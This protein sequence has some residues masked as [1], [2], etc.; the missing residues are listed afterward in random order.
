MSPSR[1]A[2]SCST[3]CRPMKPVAPVT[4]YV[5]TLSVLPGVQTPN[6]TSAHADVYHSRRPALVRPARTRQDPQPQRERPPARGGVL[7]AVVNDEAAR[8]RRARQPERAEAAVA[9]AAL[10]DERDAAGSVH[11]AQVA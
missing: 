9:G 6:P 7:E 3:R 1:L 5:G 10:R 8:A 2:S 11:A 4:K